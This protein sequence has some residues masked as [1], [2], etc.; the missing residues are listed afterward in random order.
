MLESTLSS[1]PGLKRE[2][3]RGTFFPSTTVVP[4]RRLVS[5][6]KWS[7]SRLAPTMPRPIPV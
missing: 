3:K 6:L 5:I 7:I 1:S 2:N 4:C